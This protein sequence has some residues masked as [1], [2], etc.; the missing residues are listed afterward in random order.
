MPRLH[1]VAKQANP[2]PAELVGL[3]VQQMAEVIA[4]SLAESTAV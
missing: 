1:A 3:A 4:R 2:S